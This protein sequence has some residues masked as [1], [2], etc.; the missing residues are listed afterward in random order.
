MRCEQGPDLLRPPDER[1][2]RRRGRGPGF[3][4]GTGPPI[5]R[6]HRKRRRNLDGSGRRQRAITDRLVEGRR[7]GQRC[8]S[9]LPIEDGHQR[10]VLADRSAAVTSGE[11][12]D[13]A[14][15]R[16]LVQLIELHAPFRGRGRRGQVAPRRRVLRYAVQ[17]RANEPV[18]RARPH[19]MPIVERRAVAKRE[20]GEER[21]PGERCRAVEGAGIAGCRGPFHLGQVQVERFLERDG[22]PIDPQPPIME[23]G[24]QH[25]Q[26]AAERTAC[27]LVVRLRPQHGCELVPR[28][29]TALHREQ[30]KDRERLPRV[31]E[32]RRP[33]DQ[34]VE[35]TEDV[36]R[37]AWTALRR[38][39][40]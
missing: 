38:H 1:E 37:Q 31:H 35:G 18:G 7:L 3:R 23:P 27:R 30:H 16:A 40:A 24:P 10:P 11:Q 33:I 29:G 20:T 15:V 5:G 14:P 25:R 22:R 6:T 34:D 28:K 4:R 9:Q 26:R 12:R 19:R 17:D 21:T 8:D 39:R 32:E 36:D 13:Q 2:D